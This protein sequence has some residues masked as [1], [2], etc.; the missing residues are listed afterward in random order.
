M[1]TGAVF[2][3][4]NYRKDKGKTLK[5]HIVKDIA[6]RRFNTRIEEIQEKHW[7]AIEAKDAALALLNDDLKNPEHDNIAL[8]VQR[9]VYKEQLQ[10]CENIV[11]HLKKLY[12]PQAKNHGKDNI[13]M[14]IQK[15]TTPEENEKYNGLRHNIPIIDL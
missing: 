10:I 15:N 12:V 3:I 9:D 1:L 5:K 6:P 4:V 2:V 7:Q 11:T 8:Q 14:I 13:I